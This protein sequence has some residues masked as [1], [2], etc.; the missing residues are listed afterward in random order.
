MISCSL[1]V[2][3]GV[4]FRLQLRHPQSLGAPI[5]GSDV[6]DFFEN[7]DFDRFCNV[8]LKGVFL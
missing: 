1:P 3:I 7:N 5:R 8:I 4:E 2:R 6:H